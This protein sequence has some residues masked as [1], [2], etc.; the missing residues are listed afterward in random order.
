MPNLSPLHETACKGAVSPPMTSINL[1]PPDSL[2]L[3]AV[4]PAL[5]T[6]PSS[7]P[8]HTHGCSRFLALIFPLGSLIN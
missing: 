3:L 1:Q 5:S 8:S 6:R 4:D 7:P 2:I